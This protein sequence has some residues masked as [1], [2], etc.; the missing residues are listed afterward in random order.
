[1]SLGTRNDTTIIEILTLHP[2]EMEL[3]KAIRNRWKFGEI[4]IM[5]R[6]GLPFRLLRT[7]EF[8]DLTKADVI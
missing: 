4:T 6:N 1:M 7:Q 2:Q 5:A 8:I 3:L